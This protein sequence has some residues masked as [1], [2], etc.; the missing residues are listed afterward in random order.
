MKDILF[1]FKIYFSNLK[2]NFFRSVNSF[3]QGVKPTIYNF[4]LHICHCGFTSRGVLLEFVLADHKF[5]LFSIN[6]KF[7][8]CVICPFYTHIG[9]TTEI[10][11]N[12]YIFFYLN[13]LTLQWFEGIKTWFGLA[14]ALQLWLRG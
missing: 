4:Q 11:Q 10:Y 13:V 9:N 6:I 5:S 14:R 8:L 3:L 1:Y 12:L 2:R 7:K